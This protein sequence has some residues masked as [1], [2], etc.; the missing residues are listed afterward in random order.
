LSSFT[1]EPRFFPTTSEILFSANIARTHLFPTSFCL[2]IDESQ[3]FDMT[4]KLVSVE[5]KKHGLR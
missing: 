3:L 5:A 2:F 1:I 4:L